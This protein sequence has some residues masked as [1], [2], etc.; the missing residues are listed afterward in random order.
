MV[1][2][3]VENAEDHR[4]SLAP[5]P[6]KNHIWGTALSTGVEGATE[7]A[8]LDG[9]MADKPH[10]VA[11]KANGVATNFVLNTAK[12]STSATYPI[13]V[14]GVLQTTELSGQTVDDFTFTIAPADGADIIAFYGIA[15]DADE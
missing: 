11:F 2:S 6:V 8:I 15:K 7:A 14:N 5:T 1:A 9:F 4:Y 10:L 3:F 13:W 12:P